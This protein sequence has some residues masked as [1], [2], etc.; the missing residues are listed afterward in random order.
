VTEKSVL[1]PPKEE[2]HPL[3]IKKQEIV[4]NDRRRAS[5]MMLPNNKKLAL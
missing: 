5:R 4:A 3:K 1:E 2:P